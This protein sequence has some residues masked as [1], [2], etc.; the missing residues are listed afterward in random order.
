V[1]EHPEFGTIFGPAGR[2]EV[3]LV[4]TVGG[5]AIS[6][7]VDRLV[8]TPEAVLVVDFKTNRPAPSDPSAV[9][10]IYLRQMAAYRQALGAIYPDRPVRCALL[11]TDGPRLMP[12]P[13]PLL[14]KH[15]P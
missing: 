9:P 3:P 7:Q 4:G 1:L 12:L 13:D 2:A 5:R 6:A 8:V 14:E 10:A 11:W 15:A